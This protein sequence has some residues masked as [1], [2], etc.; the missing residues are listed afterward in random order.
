MEITKNGNSNFIDVPRNHMGGGGSERQLS[1]AL[2][3]GPPKLLS[4]KLGYDVSCLSVSSNFV[5]SLR[6]FFDFND[7]RKRKPCECI[8]DSPHV[9]VPDVPAITCLR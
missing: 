7:R 6:L 9:S 8:D 5:T 1:E 2:V 4:K 3:H